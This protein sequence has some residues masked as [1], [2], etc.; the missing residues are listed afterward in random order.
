MLEWFNGIFEWLISWAG[1]PY[2]P[3]IL[4]GV[5]LF[6]SGALFF[7]PEPILIAM[8]VARP[9]GALFYAAV[10]TASSVLGAALPYF[11]GRLGGRPLAERFVA[12]AR[13]DAAEDFFEDHGALTTGIAAFTP[14]PYPLFALAAG[15]TNLNYL[16]FV[17]AS[18]AG[19]GARFFG[20]GLAIYFFGPAI[21]DLI[22]DYL[23]WTTLAIGILLAL[24]YV[25]GHHVNS[26]FER[27]SKEK[28]RQ[29]QRS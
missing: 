27:R 26:R 8:S 21:Q 25:A 15:I 4:F 22:D 14:V 1:S 7:P 9:N 16:T 10:A 20:L 11:V 24:V 3:L 29:R 5:S 13:L 28:R 18:L 19:R 23:G 12:Q 6:D 17:L 2:A